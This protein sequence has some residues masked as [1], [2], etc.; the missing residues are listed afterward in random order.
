MHKRLI[1]SCFVSA[2][3]LFAGPAFAQ[4]VVHALSGTVTSVNPQTKTMTVTTPDGSSNQFNLVSDPKKEIDFNKDVRDLAKPADSF[5]AANAHVVVFFYGNDT[6]RNAIAVE[7]LGAGPFINRQGTV[8]KTNKHDHTLTIKNAKG[9]AETFHM[10]PKSVA[11]TMDGVV[12]ADHWEPSKGDEI[13]VVATTANGT[14]TALF[15]H[16]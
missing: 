4:E 1:Q 12:Q 16:D 14:E 5:D 15:V 11:D 9:K 3:L 7:D 2:C 10:D 13:S 6:V 8:T